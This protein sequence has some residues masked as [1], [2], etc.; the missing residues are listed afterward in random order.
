M[1]LLAYQRASDMFDIAR[2]LKIFNPVTFESFETMLENEGFQSLVIIN[3]CVV[4]QMN[5]IV[6]S[7]SA[8]DFPIC[9]FRNLR[10]FSLKYFISHVFII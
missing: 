3:L 4:K 1:A 5:A 7:V 2:S 6:E 8:A 9:D 10:S